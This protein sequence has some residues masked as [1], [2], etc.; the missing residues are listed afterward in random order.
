MPIN[1]IA[2]ETIKK[3]LFRVAIVN[4]NL[5]CPLSITARDGWR[6]NLIAT[7]PPIQVTA[8]KTWIKRIILAYSAKKALTLS[9]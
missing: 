1:T 2:V 3:N 5:F 4:S 9:P 8:N 6:A 7:I